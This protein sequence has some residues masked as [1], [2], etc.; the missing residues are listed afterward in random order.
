MDSMFLLLF[1]LCWPW[2]LPFLWMVT[3]GFSWEGEGR[4][5]DPESG[6]RGMETL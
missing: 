1:L 5:L 3:R 2:W 6:N 4:V